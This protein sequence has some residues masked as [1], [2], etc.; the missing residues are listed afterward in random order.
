MQRTAP[1]HREAPPLM[2]IALGRLD[3]QLDSSSIRVA[4]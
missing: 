3:G 2:P 4:A 1:V